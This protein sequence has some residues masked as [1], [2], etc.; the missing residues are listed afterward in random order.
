M[1]SRFFNYKKLCI[2]ALLFR[3]DFF[4]WEFEVIHRI[5]LVIGMIEPS[6][7]SSQQKPH[8]WKKLEFANFDSDNGP[9]D[10]VSHVLHNW[11]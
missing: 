3:L 4:D 5:I 2:T 10:L 1:K 9:Q 8:L 7:Y 11:E 6:V